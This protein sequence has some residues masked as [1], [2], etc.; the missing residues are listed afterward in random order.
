MKNL[1]KNIA[2]AIALLAVFVTGCSNDVGGSMGNKTLL[3]L[4]SQQ[5]SN[6]NITQ[7]TMNALSD[8]QLVDFSD[9]R[10]V[11]PAALKAS[12]MTFYYW[13]TDT[14]NASNNTSLNT[15][16]VVTFNDSGDGVTGTIAVNLSVSAYKLKLVGCLNTNLPA[17]TTV[18]AVMEKAV[19]YGVA[20][21][22]LRYTQSI[23]FYLSPNNVSGTGSVDIFFKTEG[24]WTNEAYSV[25]VR[26][27]DKSSG[28][29]LYAHDSTAVGASTAQAWYAIGADWTTAASNT[30]GTVNTGIATDAGVEYKIEN[31]KDGEYNLVV[32]YYNGVKH[33]FWSDTLIVLAGQCSNK[34]SVNAGSY[35]SVNDRYYIILPNNIENPPTPPANLR[36]GYNDPDN[37]DGGK[38]LAT[39]EWDDKSSNEEYFLFELLDVTDCNTGT[40]T[41][42]TNVTGYDDDTKAALASVMANYPN[43]TATNALVDNDNATTAVGSWPTLASHSKVVR[44]QYTNAIYQDFNTLYGAGSLNKNSTSLSLW[45]DLGHSYVA[46]I[47]AYNDASGSQSATLDSDKTAGKTSASK[48][49]YTNTAAL[50]TTAPRTV[51]MDTTT[52]GLTGDT[53][54]PVKWTT[55]PLCVNRFRIEYSLNGGSF[56]EVDK[57]GT[58]KAWPPATKISDI[59]VLTGY[60]T[61]YDSI[62]STGRAIIDPT[63]W[64]NNSTTRAVDLDT[65]YSASATSFVTLYSGENSFKAWYKNVILEGNLYSKINWTTGS[66]GTTFTGAS[67]DT[68]VNTKYGNIN[69]EHGDV[70]AAT[71]D[72]DSTAASAT[73]SLNGKLYTN[74]LMST[75]TYFQGGN[76]Y[77]VACYGS[78]AGDVE[79]D[80]PY[81]YN[82]YSQNIRLYKMWGTANATYPFTTSNNGAT[83]GYTSSGSDESTVVCD[84]P[85]KA[86]DDGE[87]SSGLFRISSYYKNLSI[88]LVENQLA[89]SN[90]NTYKKVEVEVLDAENHSKASVTATETTYVCTTTTKGTAL[91][92]ISGTS[93][94]A[95][96]GAAGSDPLLVYT[97]STDYTHDAYYYVLPL[98]ILTPGQKYSIK[99]KGFTDENAKVP[100]E[101]TLNFEYTDPEYDMTADANFTEVTSYTSTTEGTYYLKNGGKYK[102]SPYNCPNASGLDGTGDKLYT[103]T[104]TPEY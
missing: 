54:T 36:V 94:T 55:A 12:E 63:I 97:T 47:T 6:S 83:G 49:I 11:L 30:T 20:D 82:I 84:Y 81:N 51:V 92:K 98:S 10:T 62:T 33:T 9:G 5:N 95:A 101:Y 64:A 70:G 102:V 99:V 29:E 23:N 32:D 68:Y 52:G 18:T 88:L 1:A 103:L 28:T 53:Y 24:A 16:K 48:W 104:G 38:F 39:F 42:A 44:Y 79:I 13:G 56:Y 100:Y 31:I 78:D 65:T 37:R 76:L 26:I 46:R 7:L 4:L 75:P 74:K 22:D 69:G 90:D 91:E 8:D 59:E 34:T 2:L 27:E 41:T 72:S 66:A 96:A 25:T 45:L 15:P 89:A 14:I 71:P 40:I 86:Y 19:V 35:D 57:W 77:L 3:A 80:D 73:D 43:V 50:T 17:S 61:Y 21:V 87:V 85:G 58:P 67:T 93:T 60:L